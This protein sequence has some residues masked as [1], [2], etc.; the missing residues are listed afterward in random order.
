MMKKILKFNQEPDYPLLAVIF[1]L[2]VFGLIILASASSSIAKEKFDD[3]FYYLKRQILYGFLPGFFGFLFGY[4]FN[5]KNYKKIS[6]LLLIINIFLLILVK[7]SP[8]GLNFGGSSRWLR[9]GPIV[10]Q[11]SELLK[12][13]YIFYVAAW[14]SNV[15]ANRTGD[16][17]KGFLP[18]IVV[19]G[20]IGFLLYIQP[21]TSIIMI[22][23]GSG[24]LLYLIGG[25]RLKYFSLIFFVGMI[26]I[27]ILYFFGSGYR[28]Q[29]IQSFLNPNEDIYGGAYHLNQAL[30]TV[31]SG[32]LTGFGFGKSTTKAKTLPEPLGDSI[33]AVSSQE[34]GFIGSSFLVLTLAFLV[35]RLFWLAI[36]YKE[37]FGQLILCGFG[38][39]IGIQSI[40]HIAV[41]IGFFPPTGIPLPFVSYGGTSL[42]VLMTMSGIALNITRN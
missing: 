38:L 7:F 5:Y 17:F 14:L 3:S 13:T 18:F 41:L 42:A 34:L 12:I 37:R 27:G 21:A 28:F 19:S 40:I 32:G 24:A 20:L 16:L 29:R 30:I 6:L 22:V 33:F 1:I 9:L 4:F 36:K 10:F 25:A 8:L 23:L 39:I 26:G 15:R 2:V 31:G 35:I 11:P